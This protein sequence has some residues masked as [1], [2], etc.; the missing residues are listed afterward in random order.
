M[1]DSSS[2][3]SWLADFVHACVGT[4][5]TMA[6]RGVCWLGKKRGGAGEGS[7]RNLE[8]K[9]RKERKREKKKKDGKQEAGERTMTM[10][11]EEEVEGKEVDEVGWVQRN[12]DEMKNEPCA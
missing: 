8:L 1:F 6:E 12:D 10:R 5:T 11:P 7:T 9:K 4:S 3:A 2:F